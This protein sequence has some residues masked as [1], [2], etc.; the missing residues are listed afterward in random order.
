ML[1]V[2][3]VD[4]MTLRDAEGTSEFP[5][6]EEE[7]CQREWLLRVKGYDA[8]MVTAAAAADVVI[9]S[10]ALDELSKPMHFCKA[11]C[12]PTKRRSEGRSLS[13]AD[14]AEIDG[15]FDTCG[16]Q[17]FQG[18]SADEGRRARHLLYTWRDILEAGAHKIKGT[19]LTKDCRR[20][21]SYTTELPPT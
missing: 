6:T 9:P 21:N 14:D 19:D 4:Y 18:L 12:F 20:D 13:T 16:I 15:W 10:K 5:T 8:R 2:R 3:I 1:L 11:H 7:W 17:L